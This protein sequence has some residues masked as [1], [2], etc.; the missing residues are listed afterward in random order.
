MMNFITKLVRNFK[1]TIEIQTTMAQ[2]KQ[3]DFTSVIRESS[4]VEMF[5][6][7][8][9]YQND[10]L[11]TGALGLHPRVPNA[12][13]VALYNPATQEPVFAIVINQ[14]FLDWNETFK[15]VVYFHEMG[16]IN[17]RHY[18]NSQLRPSQDEIKTGKGLYFQ[19]ELEADMYAVQKM[20]L[21]AVTEW[22][23]SMQFSVTERKV[24][25]VLNHRIANLLSQY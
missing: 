14:A 20:G 2:L 3:K 1:D 23:V 24:I 16:H 15:K 10:F 22:L 8:N 13:Q 9:V 7:V 5:E 11:V 4:V 6:G 19:N 25:Q 18:L 21:K 17:A 12:L